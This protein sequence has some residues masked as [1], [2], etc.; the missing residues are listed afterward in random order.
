M[1][2]DI[3]PLAPLEMHSE[4]V[5]GAI[6]AKADPSL[7]SGLDHEQRHS[8]H[9]SLQPTRHWLNADVQ[10]RIFPQENV[11]LEVDRHGAD[12]NLKHWNQFSL[13]MIS[14]SSKALVGDIGRFDYGYSHSSS[15][16]IIQ[17]RTRISEPF[18]N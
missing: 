14:D 4:N 9:H 6:A 17:I 7:P 5:P 16:L 11:V 18:W 12:F 15:R 8:R 10:R 1:L 13:N 2:S 3:Q